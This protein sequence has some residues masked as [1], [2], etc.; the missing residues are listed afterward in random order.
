MYKCSRCLQYF[1]NNDL[2]LIEGE[3]H[4]SICQ[5]CLSDI[6]LDNSVSITS[7]MDDDDY[8]FMDI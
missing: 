2:V 6:R 8:E 3:E 4:E 7:C 1:D 5:D